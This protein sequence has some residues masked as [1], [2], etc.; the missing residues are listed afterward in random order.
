MARLLALLAIWLGTYALSATA[1]NCF[2]DQSSGPIASPEGKRA[3]PK[4]CIGG[5]PTGGLWACEDPSID[6]PTV[7]CLMA[8]MLTCGIITNRAPSVFYSFHIEGGEVIS[9]LRDRI[10]PTGNT[11]NDE[12]DPQYWQRVTRDRKSIFRLDINARLQVFIARSAEA[13]ARL[14]SGDVFVYVPHLVC[15]KEPNNGLLGSFQTSILKPGNPNPGPSIF[16]TFELPALQRNPA[17]TRIISIDINNND[18]Q[19]VDWEN[20]ESPPGPNNPLM[21]AS[22]ASAIVVPPVPAA[23]EPF[24]RD[25]NT[26]STTI[27]DPPTLC[28]LLLPVSTAT[29]S[30]VASSGA[31]TITSPPGPPTC[32]LHQQDPDQGIT[33]AFC[34]CDS[35]AT[36]SP[37]SVPLTGHSNDSCSYTTIPATTKEAVTTFASVYTSKC[38]ACTEVGLKAPSCTGIAKCTPT[39]GQ[40]TVQAGSSA[41]HIK[42]LEIGLAVIA[43]E[44]ALQDVA[45]VPEVQTFCAGTFA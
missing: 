34:P 12:W 10:T 14:A 32:V 5:P 9:A 21:P 41:V 13:Y 17:V 43:P 30:T 40:V 45:T 4:K 3:P 39:I 26:N 29:T 36:L 15:P 6:F 35:T 44:F 8:D 33:Q 23:M 16:Q 20:G 37:L 1:G 2:S 25:S 31:S 18:Q 7:E 42:D 22:S 24:K 38:Q 11:Y 27:P 19:H 28:P